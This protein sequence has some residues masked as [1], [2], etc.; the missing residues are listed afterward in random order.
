MNNT[1]QLTETEANEITASL[2]T[3]WA[4]ENAAKIK[5]LAHLQTLTEAEKIALFNEVMA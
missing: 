1:N 2:F 5:M 3:Q 4:N